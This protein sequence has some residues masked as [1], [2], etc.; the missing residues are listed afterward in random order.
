MARVGQA[1]WLGLGMCAVRTAREHVGVLAGDA[2]CV[3]CQR[4]REVCAVVG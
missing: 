2:Q 1:T 3:A 4:R